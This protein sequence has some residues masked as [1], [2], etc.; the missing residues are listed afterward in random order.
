MFEGEPVKEIYITKGQGNYQ[1]FL[2]LITQLNKDNIC[3]I[4]MER[5]IEDSHHLIPRRL[6]TKNPLLTELRMKICKECHE[7]IHP[8][9]KLILMVKRLTKIVLDV[10]GGYV[11][12]IKDWK[13]INTFIDK[14]E[15]ELKNE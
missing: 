11:K 10:T 8:E 14:T 3:P 6:K 9:S 13:E 2:Y 12:S 1:E 15:K 7:K 4:C 5:P